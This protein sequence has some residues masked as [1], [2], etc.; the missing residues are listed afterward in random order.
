MNLNKLFKEWSEQNLGKLAFRDSDSNKV[1]VAGF[2]NIET[3]AIACSDLSTAITTGTSKGYQRMPYDF[4]VIKVKAS[5]IVAS[6]SG[7]PTFDINE[8]GVSILSTTI[9]IDANEK[10]SDTAAT[11]AV[12]ADTVLA[13]DAEITVDI[14]VA[15][16]GAKG[17]IVYIIGYATGAA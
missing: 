10:T 14:D 5:L 13:K 6:T 4:T 11:A 1:S 8:S 7:T 16:T 9:T 12:I 15:G 17:V 2:G 3:F